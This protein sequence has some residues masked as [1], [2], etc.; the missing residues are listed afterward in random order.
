[1]KPLSLSSKF[2]RGIRPW[3]RRRILASALAVSGVL[4]LALAP[5]SE[6]ATATGKTTTTATCNYVGGVKKWV[7][8]VDPPLVQGFQLRVAYDPAEATFDATQFKNPFTDMQ[9]EFVVGN[10]VNG[11][12]VGEVL[13]YT[14][15]T[16]SAQ[17][18]PGD[19]DVFELVFK[20]TSTAV[21]SFAAQAEKVP[22]LLFADGSIQPTQAPPKPLSEVK[23]T[24]FASSTVS[25]VTNRADYLSV[26]DCNQIL[27]IDA[28]NIAPTTRA[29]IPGVNS[30]IWDPNGVY[31]DGIKGGAATWD[32]ST[33]RFD[34]LP[35]NSTLAPSVDVAWNNTLNVHD[36]AV[37]GGH[38]GT[39]IVTLQAGG[40]SAGGLQFDTPG[41]TLVGGPLTLTAPSGLKPSIDTGFNTATLDI[42]IAGTAGT[43]LEKF[44]TGTLVLT[45]DNL[46]N[47]PTCVSGGLVQISRDANLGVAGAIVLNGGGLSATTCLVLNANRGITLG[48]AG[49]TFNSTGAIDYSGVIA[50]PGALTVD[51]GVL[52]LA[53]N[54]GNNTYGGITTVNRGTL[55]ISHLGALGSAT[56][57]VVI[58]GTTVP[59][60]GGGQLVLGG[61]NT[62]INFTRGLNLSGGGPA[63]IGDALVS[64]GNNTLAA[65]VSTGSSSATRLASN[66]GTTNVTGGVAL[67][68]GQSA[69]FQGNAHWSIAGNVTGTGSLAKAGPGTLILNGANTY[70]GITT[71]S[72]GFLR[73]ASGT[74]LGP[75][76]AANA[77]TLNGGTLEARTDAPN[78]NTKGVTLATGDGTIFAD[79]AVGGS[80]LNQTVAFAGLTLVPTPAETRTLT[81]NGRNGYGVEFSSV[82]GAGPGFERIVNN[83]N[84]LVGVT[85]A[86][87]NQTD[88]TARNMRFEGSGDFLLNGNV[89]A[90]GAAHQLSMAGSGTLTINGVASTYTGPTFITGG[91]LAIRQFGALGT[92]GLVAINNGSRLNYL[93]AAGTGA[94]ETSNNSISLN[95]IGGRINAN[96][97]GSLPTPLILAGG[98]NNIGSTPN[99]VL[100]LGGASALD[101]EIQGGLAD[102]GINAVSL[103]K[104]DPGTWVLSGSNT[105]TGPTT[106]TGG[107][108]KLKANAAA[109]TILADN[110]AITFNVDATTQN[111]GGTLELVGQPSVSNLENLGPLNPQ[112][113]PGTIRL[114]PAPGGN[115]SITFASL[116]GVA[117]LGASINVVA[118]SALDI[119]RLTGVPDGFV[120]GS[121]YY[122]GSN[123]A[124]ANLGTGELRAPV[125]GAD[126]GFFTSAVALTAGAHNEVTGAGFAL[127]AGTTPINSLLID[128][129]GSPV[130]TMGAADQLQINIGANTVGGILLTG[131]SS[132]ISGGNVSQGLGAAGG[133][134]VIRV[135][136]VAD[137]LTLD[138]QLSNATV[139]GLTKNGFGILVLTNSTNAQT[140]AT[141]INEGTVRMAG[142]GRLSAANQPLALRQGAVLDLNGVNTGTAI[143][144]FNGAGIV[145]NS[146]PVAATLTVGNGNGTGTFTGII[147]Q[148]GGGAASVVKQGTGGQT[149]SG[150]NQYT[151]ST[152]INATGIVSIPNLANIGVASGLGLGDAT[153]DATN[154][155]SLVFGGASTAAAMGGI[156]YTGAPSVSI[157]RLFTFAGT[158]NGAGGRIQANGANNATL[159]LNKTN[160]ILY[161]AGANNVAQT[162]VLG[163]ASTGDN[164]MDL[165]LVNPTGGASAV[166]NVH[167]A[168]AGVWVLGNTTNTYTGTTTV[169]GGTL[170]AIDGQ[171]LPTA[172]P[173]VLNGGIFQTSGTFTR[174]F[175]LTPTP[176][177]GGVSLAGTTSGFAASPTKLT[178]NFG[179]A[180][181][182]VPFPVTTL[183]LSSATAL[184]ETELV[185]G[186]DLGAVARTILVNDNPNTST[187][188]ATLSGPIS[189][190]FAGSGT[191]A[192]IKTGPG[193]LFLKGAS[194][195]AG[196]TALNSG[197]LLITALGNSTSASSSLGAGAGTLHLGTGGNSTTLTYVGAG[198]TSDRPIRLTATSGTTTIESSGYGRIILTNVQNNSGS[199]A[200]KTLVLGGTNTDCNEVSGILSNDTGGGVLTVVQNTQAMWVLSGQSTFTGAYTTT[201]GMVGIG[202]NSTPLSGVVLSGPV[203]TGPLTVNNAALTAV[204]GDRTIGN[205]VTLTGNALASFVGSN[206]LT[207]NGPVSIGGGGTT[208]VANTLPEGKALTVNGPVT[209]SDVNASRAL[210]LTGSGL[211]ILAGVIQDN[212]VNTA[213]LT[214]VTNTSG[215]VVL[216]NSG[217]TYSSD[218]TLTS[219][220][221]QLG[222][223]EV[224]PHGVGKGNVI[225]NPG[226]GQSA[227]L[228]LNGKTETIN[229]LTANSLGTARIKNTAGTTASLSFGGG[230][231]AVLF[232]GAICG[233][234]SLTKI[235]MG[236][237]E[238]GGKNPYTGPTTVS[239]G[240]LR[241]AN[242]GAIG[243]PAVAI[244]AGA[245]LDV[246]VG[247]SIDGTVTNNGTLMGGGSIGT[248]INN[249]IV[250]PGASP[251][252]LT[253][254]NGL[255]LSGT[256]HFRLELNSTL[257]R[258]GYDQL[259]V[260]A[261]NISLG[262]DFAG[263]LVRLALT[264][265][266]LFA[267]ILNNGAGST[268]GTIGGIPNGGLFTLDRRP[269]NIYYNGNYNPGN[270]NASFLSGGNDVFLVAVPEPGVCA[271]L[272]SGLAGLLATGR[273]FRRRASAA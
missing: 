80:G 153:N 205:A 38:P 255:T 195:Y 174:N 50:G 13:V 167:K 136:G 111:A 75:N 23:F 41:Y 170:Q 258:S 138:S 206:A 30:L 32:T 126:T 238:L 58:G 10:G 91:T 191:P 61:S 44:G 19:V 248:L 9:V 214:G 261:G 172:S 17:T 68:A 57:T 98:L 54:S 128:G 237:A 260:A 162:L 1:M 273:R 245:T 119:V 179:G 171:S 110:S 232:N 28:P 117:S 250:A 175:N 243:S 123:F 25:T 227:D 257:P 18:Q 99:R 52:N 218:T 33:I 234:I 137:T 92:S 228:D 2:S 36:I 11:V 192:L 127:A 236:Q 74:N 102:A 40:I 43:G 37:F 7:M 160:P 124:L 259:V 121:I 93:G 217:N 62:P 22:P 201:S 31:N 46:Y 270:P 35:I 216:G 101:N 165:Q 39:G 194:T 184:A 103:T 157:N 226:L 66:V 90:S 79:R 87:W 116:G 199:S 15:G 177:S 222:G 268:T 81:V 220:Q 63:G 149:W 42:V 20:D 204:G 202:A 190:A 106:I 187:D 49:G 65:L 107:T 73:V 34:P 132:T 233:D 230:D 97:T 263:S 3:A 27:T 115:A 161:T 271:T 252:T 193:T 251:G 135:N 146:G 168:D 166:L 164:E 152:T 264:Q 112:Q 142:A 140:G 88:G 159:I 225:I 198:E 109:S 262:G 77:I 83:S 207:L 78:F 45:A 256:S 267:I 213:R 253:I 173:L 155:A 143:G 51:G 215:L 114:S 211:T 59:G 125:Y 14:V 8:R 221:L 183:V 21:R 235:G 210:E 144:A 47:G 29:A 84:G 108:L 244:A 181:A 197:N 16:V 122:N 82:A 272:L 176:G 229:G 249:G 72:G 6:G 182:V 186:L 113:G 196:D 100:T 269:F 156:S 56:S 148:S 189:G 105:Y 89:L 133:A 203:G 76:A 129:S 158:A 178:V 200:A 26:R 70:S 212:Q 104:T 147:T 120:R 224:V 118:P 266:D 48:T 5:E 163:G 95:G 134:L 247:G 55:E 151:G 154:A 94:G 169:A 131:G 231:Q 223:S 254:S 145:I 209:N 265:G 67:G 53:G 85:G 219:G 64:I 239:S 180:G 86:F 139:G 71:V 150:L 24:V 242:G 12:A 185:N 208:Q 246:V 241:V 96:Q 240:I 69:T 60:I 130:L 188:F 4:P 141:N